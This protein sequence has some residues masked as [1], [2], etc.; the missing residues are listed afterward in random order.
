MKIKMNWPAFVLSA[1]MLF[2]LTL[3]L[4]AAIIEISKYIIGG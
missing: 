2:L 3:L 1:L 4:I